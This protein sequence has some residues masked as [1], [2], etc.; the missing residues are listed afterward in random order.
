MNVQEIYR[1]NRKKRKIILDRRKRKA[2]HQLPESV[3]DSEIICSTNCKISNQ[4][5]EELDIGLPEYY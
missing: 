1:A 4:Y 5:F 2:R 3:E